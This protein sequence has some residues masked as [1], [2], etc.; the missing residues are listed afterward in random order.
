M[1]TYRCVD[2]MIADGFSEAI[3]RPS[4]S[5]ARA[6]SHHVATAPQLGN[7][8]HPLGH[9]EPGAPEVDQIATAAQLRRPLDQRD[10]VPSPQQPVRQ[11]RAGDPGTHD[12][13]LH[14][15]TSAQTDG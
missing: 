1:L 3:R 15:T 14:A 2:P 11:G 7:D 4:R 5:T 9:V 12:Q 13:D 8:A 6:S 10:L